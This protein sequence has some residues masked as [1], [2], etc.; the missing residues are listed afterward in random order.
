MRPRKTIGIKKDIR[1]D[2]TWNVN[3]ARYGSGRGDL[4]LLAD[5]DHAGLPVDHR[6]QSVVVDVLVDGRHR[7]EHEN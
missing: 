3:A 6:Q 5:V 1:D 2:I 4:E 7:G